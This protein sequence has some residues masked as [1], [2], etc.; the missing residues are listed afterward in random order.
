MELTLKK[1]CAFALA[2]VALILLWKLFIVL[3]GF[4]FKA[5]FLVLALLLCMWVY[6][7]FIKSH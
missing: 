5:V 1:V 4:A 7:T 3:L 6:K 2:I